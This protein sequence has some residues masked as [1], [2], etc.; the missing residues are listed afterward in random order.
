MLGAEHHPEHNIMDVKGVEIPSISSEEEKGESIATTEEDIFNS[1]DTQQFS[2]INDSEAGKKK[3]TNSL[4][5]TNKA[6]VNITEDTFK[7]KLY[8]KINTDAFSESSVKSAGTMSD[9]EVVNRTRKVRKTM[10]VDSLKEQLSQ[11]H[12][13]KYYIPNSGDSRDFESLPESEQDEDEEESVSKLRGPRL[14]F[15]EMLRENMRRKEPGTRPSTPSKR[16]LNNAT[17]KQAV[18]PCPNVIDG[19]LE[20]SNFDNPY[21]L[22]FDSH[23]NLYIADTNHHKIRKISY[24]SNVTETIAGNTDNPVYGLW[25]AGGYIDGYGTLTKFNNPRAIAVYPNDKELL[26]ADEANDVIR[27]ISLDKMEVS[28]FVGTRR[29]A[30]NEDG[31]GRDAKLYCPVAVA[32]DSN[33]NAYFS[34]K[35]HDHRVQKIEPNGNVTHFAG[36]VSQYLGYADGD[37]T[38]CRFG[39]ILGLA[40]DRND[41]VYISDA[42]DNRIR[43][44]TPDGE[45]STIAGPVFKKKRRYLDKPGELDPPLG[46][47]GTSDG[48]AREA[49]FNY[50]TGIAVDHV[51]NVYICDS[52]NDRVRR[53]NRIHPLGPLPLSHAALDDSSL[54]RDDMLQS[55]D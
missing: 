35:P 13:P 34:C 42:F 15:E 46:D 30:G 33:S 11:S 43:M 47:P 27:K 9:A 28:T 6:T 51:G 5:N 17:R 50:P 41:N 2:E 45:V 21:G 55:F 36:S 31:F 16:I 44:A 1:E 23:G 12:L 49:S 39:R 32:I 25:S 18:H 29:K 7:A 24:G 52:G 38:T 20:T 14:P 37:A 40:V 19:P 8:N 3:D 26:I 10:D 54:A 53:L 22:A 48:L 4:K